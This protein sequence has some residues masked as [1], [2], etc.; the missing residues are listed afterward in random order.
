MQLNEFVGMVMG[1][2]SDFLKDGQKVEFDIN[3]G[4]FPNEDGPKT[5]VG[6]DLSRLRFHVI[7]DGAKQHI[8]EVNSIY[9][10]DVIMQDVIEM[11]KAGKSE[12]AIAK[13]LGI[14]DSKVHRLKA[15]AKASG[16]L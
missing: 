16:R 8:S 11:T 10:Q 12:R 15:K 1:Q 7:F 14:S 5:F 4:L 13:E 6:Q 9:I 2:L 3:V